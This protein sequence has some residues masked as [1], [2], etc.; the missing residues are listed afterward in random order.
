MGHA[1][2]EM[3]TTPA[4]AYLNGDASNAVEADIWRVWRPPKVGEAIP[5][6]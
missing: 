1:W 4:G 2:K 3:T 5:F 6:V